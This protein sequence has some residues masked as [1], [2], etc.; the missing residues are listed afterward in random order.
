MNSTRRFLLCAFVVFCIT[1]S[2]DQAP[3][4]ADCNNATIY[5][6]G[7]CGSSGWFTAYWDGVS[8]CER[9]PERI[10]RAVAMPEPLF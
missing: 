4:R 10:L 5:N 9:R 3:L 8:D 6:Q 7:G 2:F 1:M